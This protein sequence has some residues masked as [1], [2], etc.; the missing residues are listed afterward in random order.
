VEH[1]KAA[2]VTQYLDN[3]LEGG[4]AEGNGDGLNV[5]AGDAEADPMYDQAVQV[6]LQ[7][8]RPSISLVQ[9]HLRIGYNRAA[10]LIEQMERSG[11]VS[12]MQTNG[13]REVLVPAGK[14]D[15]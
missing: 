4:S 13:N 5:D 2:G 1:L 12:A 9:R 8:R 7:T 10:R 6:V 11:L 15:A 3:I 14:G